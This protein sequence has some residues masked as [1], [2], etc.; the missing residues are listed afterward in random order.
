MA[1]KKTFV[2]KRTKRVF[3][4]KKKS[5]LDPN[6]IVN[7]TPAK[8]QHGLPP[9]I[10]CRL[11]YQDQSEFITTALN[12]YK[13]VANG[14]YDT[15]FTGIGHQPPFFDDISGI[16]ER[17]RVIGGK[18]R[19]TLVNLAAVPVRVF[20]QFA[21]DEGNAITGNQSTY[22]YNNSANMKSLILTPSGG[23]RDMTT[24]TLGKNFATTC[25]RELYNSNIYVGTKTANPSRKLC[26]NFGAMSIDGSTALNIQWSADI[27]YIAQFLGQETDAHTED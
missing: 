24:L 27:T 14:L 15:D 20:L 8:G 7:I 17:H 26:W 25:G 23:S 5:K 19:V 6:A 16:Y 11:L 2:K 21:D 3:K 4:R 9:R 18:I 22:D 13:F 1:K 12:N 10:Q